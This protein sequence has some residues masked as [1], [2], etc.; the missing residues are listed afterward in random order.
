MGEADSYANGG[1]E[2]GPPQ[3]WGQQQQQQYG[4]PYGQQPYG[5]QPYQQQQQQYQEP[6]QQQPQ[7]GYNNQSQDPNGYQQPPQGQYGAPPP[8][9]F[10]PPKGNDPNYSFDE[11]FK[12]EKPK[13]NDLWAGILVCLHTT[14]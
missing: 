6:Q 5:Q 14:P 2:R 4:Q 3:Q 11:A 12:V 8:Y 13:Y 1:N 7:Q 10:N 9:S